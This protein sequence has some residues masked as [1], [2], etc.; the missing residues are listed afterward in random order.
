MSPATHKTIAAAQ[1]PELPLPVPDP[2]DCIAAPAGGLGA[3]STTPTEYGVS[4]LTDGAPF[5]PG[6][7]AGGSLESVLQTRIDQLARGYTA[8]HDAQAPDCFL[9][10]QARSYLHTAALDRAPRGNDAPQAGL[11]RARRSYVRAAALLLA[12]I[13]R[14]DFLTGQQAGQPEGTEPD[15]L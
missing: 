12:A 8:S 15:A 11:L 1:S 7:G 5:L 14:I 4:K 3:P 6:T 13:D 9:E 2:S 10:N